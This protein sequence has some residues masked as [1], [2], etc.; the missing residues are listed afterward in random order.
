MPLV[1]DPPTRAFLEALAALP[2]IEQV[3]VDYARAGT[4][5]GQ[6]GGARAPAEIAD[7]VIPAGPHG[8]L[9]IRV[10]RPVGAVGPLPGVVYFHG[11]GWVVG[12]AESYDRFAREIAVGSGAAV[13]FVDYKRAPEARFPA[14][15]E[16]AYAAVEWVRDNGAEIG[17][18][19]DRLALAGDSAG[20][21]IAASVARLC[22]IRAGPR[23]LLQVLLCP[24]T[25]AS[26]D[27]PSHR[28]FAK[29]PFVT[30]AAMDWFLDHYQPDV[31]ARADPILSPLES[32]LADLRGLAPAL[33]VT[34]E[35]DALRDEGEAYARRLVEAGVPVTAT[36][37][38]STIHTFMVENQLAGT[39][40]SRAATEQICSALR[41][42]LADDH[43]AQT[44]T[45]P[46][47]APLG[48]MAS[49]AEFLREFESQRWPL[50]R[51]RHRDHVRLAYLCLRA[52]T[53]AAA[54]DRVRSGIKAHNAAHGVPDGPVSGYHETMTIA[55]LRLVEVALAEYGPE[56]TADAFCDAHPELMEKK[57]LRL[58][59]SRDLFMSEQAK[60]EFVEPDLAPLPVARA[61]R[62]AAQHD[63][64][65]GA[66]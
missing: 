58:F 36:R 13:V 43:G 31:S 34:A 1:L 23:L 18:R 15:H 20:G 19:G 22:G 47:H 50:E 48:F 16:E 39:T 59:Y 65:E 11:G 55:W 4:R 25:S 8:E 30:R 24:N 49:D 60:R 61:L 27:F 41:A 35:Y 53:F 29:G 28:E 66:R 3:S 12:D 57:S 14:I 33:V 63:S 64:R 62:R 52:G 6:A 10:I 26:F 38:L 40:P 44:A 56:A 32:P 54:A 21:N 51:W 46:R 7:R 2:P 45:A 9:K 17:V 42:A 5:L 37:Y